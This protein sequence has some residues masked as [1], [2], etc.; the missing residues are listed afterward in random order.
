MSTLHDELAALRDSAAADFTATSLAHSTGPVRRRVRRDR[1]VTASAGA[2][3]VVALGAGTAYGVSLGTPDAGLAPAGTPSTSPAPE[4]TDFIGTYA[5]VH[6]AAGATAD[7]MAEQ[8]AD[9]F[10]VW[11]SDARDALDAQVSLT[12]AG[13]ITDAEGWISPGL[14]SVDVHGTLEEAAETVTF[15]RAAEL[16]ELGID[17][18]NI[19]ALTIASIIDREVKTDA[20]TEDGVSYRAMVSAVIANRLAAD[21]PLQLDSTLLYALD[22]GGPF[23]SDDERQT[24]SPYNTYLYTGL[25]P[26]PISNPSAEAIE[27]ALH[28]ADTDALYFVMTNLTN[29]E[30]G[31]ASTYDQ[32][33][34]NVERLQAWYAENGADQP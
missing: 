33:L 31:F 27:A 7:Q 1:A 8:L 12:T 18:S 4:Q 34:A 25:P 22:E 6:M 19:E 15:G 24:D 23:T 5:Q 13:Q 14:Y 10:G 3:A 21:M 32:H 30:M 11:T 20:V 28:P 17:E 9:I 2:F 29:G 26:T 16:A